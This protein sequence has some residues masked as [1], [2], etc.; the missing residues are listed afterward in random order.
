MDRLLRRIVWALRRRRLDAELQEELQFHLDMAAREHQENGLA[1]GEARRAA[2]RQLGSP[3]RV[4]EAS[5][6]LWGWRW[7]DELATDLRIGLRSLCRRWSMTATA[8]ASL[9]LGMGGA[10][11]IFTVVHSVLLRPLALRD[12]AALVRVGAKMPGMPPGFSSPPL[13]DYVAWREKNSFLAE[14]G[15]LLPRVEMNLTGVDAPEW[16]EGQ[17]ATASLFSALGVPPLL[18]RTIA[19]RDEIRGAAPVAVLGHNLWLRRFGGNAEALG[20]TLTID[21]VPH[22][23]IGV[24]PPGFGIPHD[25]V[26]AWTPFDL[27]ADA[28]RDSEDHV[29]VVA[30]LP[31]GLGLEPARAAMTALAVQAASELGGDPREIRGEVTPLHEA[32]LGQAKTRIL[33]LGGAVICLLLIA[34]ANVAG[35]LLAAAA[36]RFPESALRTA[37]GAGRARLVR[38]FL[39]ES[40]LLSAAGYA[41]GLALAALA[42]GPLVR[43]SP[44]ELPRRAEIHL[45]WTVVVC[46]AGLSL[47]TGLVFGLIPALAGSR[48]GLARWMNASG[49]R[50]AGTPVRQGARKVLVAAQVAVALTLA[51]GAGLMIQSLQRLLRVDAG[52]DPGGVYTFQVRLPETEYASVI[53]REGRATGFSVVSPRAPARFQ[54]ILD[55]L[56]ALPGIESAS[57][58]PWLPMNG[59]FWEVRR[60]SIV[61]RP[62]PAPGQPRPGAGYNPVDPGIFR[63]LRIPLVRGRLLNHRDT[64]GSPWVAV[65]NETLARTWLPG[66]DPIGQYLHFP[67]FGDARPR[68][69]VG[70]VKDL[71]QVALNREPQSQIYFPFVQLP[72]ENHTNRVRSRL[73]MSFLVRTSLTE[74]QAPP[75]LRE[76]VRG[77][78]RDIPMF[79]VQPLSQYLDESARETRFLTLL[80]G[81]FAGIALM[82]AAVGLFGV[83]NYAVARRTSEIGVRVA[84]GAK[85]GDMARLVLREACGVAFAGVAAGL[86]LALALTR[87]LGSVVFEIKPGD[88]ATL[89][90]ASALLGATA[91]AASYLPAHRASRVDPAVAL[92]AE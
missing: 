37:L 4:R 66:Q 75:Q 14:M 84:L 55:E 3:I 45:D 68:Q 12:P 67:D 73:H 48:P 65:I 34:C 63:T 54:E 21:G 85:P 36:E 13:A 7:L 81:A 16:A 6:E 77:V 9:A 89:A 82:L 28:V 58:I 86:G 52:F 30:R 15:A 61:G 47:F 1:P 42:V 60:F 70:V 18:G 43:L 32:L 79:A 24:M 44:V 40:L 17:K 88:P 35:L 62:Q 20:K 33:P 23:V 69:I 71:R 53:R 5:R 2:S 38:L 80:L 11:T 59:Y 90:A 74:G 27:S 78:D 76:A 64:A 92:R 56:R 10:M 8:V 19:A 22:E 26:A 46:A 39:A 72:P 57:A 51:A 50:T 29:Q 87:F 25:R 41:L 49:R 31:S 83:M 91:L